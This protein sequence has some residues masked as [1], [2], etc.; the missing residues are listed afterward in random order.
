[1]LQ[2]PDNTGQISHRSPCIAVGY[3]CYAAFYT[4]RKNKNI[5]SKFAAFYT[6]MV[7]GMLSGA[8]ERYRTPEPQPSPQQEK[9]PENAGLPRVALFGNRAH[10]Q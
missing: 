4:P 3:N 2:L 8:M 5:A 6:L 9:D 1:L 7:L 10:R